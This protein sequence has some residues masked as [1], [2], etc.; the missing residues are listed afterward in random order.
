[1]AKARSVAKDMLVAIAVQG[2][3]FAV[4]AVSAFVVPRVVPV[5]SFGYWQLFLF[6]VGYLGH[7]SGRA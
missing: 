7:F 4:S 6:Y 1:M 3:A 5:E 2:L